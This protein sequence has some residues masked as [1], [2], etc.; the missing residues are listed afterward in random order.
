MKLGEY[1]K[2]RRIFLKLTQSELSTLL[3]I[4]PQC[5]S[6]YENEKTKIPLSIVLDLCYYL[7]ININDF[8][9]L[10]SHNNESLINLNEYNLDNVHK[11]IAFYR[12]KSKLTLKELSKKIGIS[13]QRLSDFELDKAS[14]SIDE[15]ILICNFYQTNYDDM[16]LLKEG[17]SSPQKIIQNT[18]KKPSKKYLY[19]GIAGFLVLASLSSLAISLGVM[20]S[21]PKEKTPLTTPTI[22]KFLVRNSLDDQSSTT[23]LIKNKDYYLFVYLDNAYNYPISSFEINKKVYEKE[24]FNEESTNKKVVVKFNSSILNLGTNDIVVNGF[25]YLNQDNKENF[26]A[27][28][29]TKYSLN[30]LSDQIPSVGIN[31]S[32]ISPTTIGGN[33]VIKNDTSDVLSS[34]EITLSLNENGNHIK[35]I[36]TKNDFTFNNLKPETEYQIIGTIKA[37]FY[38]GEGEKERT[39]FSIKLSTLPLASFE[40]LNSTYNSISYKLKIN[41]DKNITFTKLNLVD[42]ITNEII[43]E[44]KELESTINN[45]YSNHSYVFKYYV[46]NSFTDA[47]EELTKEIKTKD[48]SKP[49]IELEVINL[50]E[51]SF[52]IKPSVN[53][54]L[55]NLKMN[56]IEL[57]S[58]DSEKTIKFIDK[59]DIYSFT[60]LFSDSSYL[61]S[62][63]YSYDLLDGNGPINDTINLNVTTKSYVA[64]KVE[65]ERVSCDDTS[66]L[67]I[68]KEVKDKISPSYLKTELYKDEILQETTNLANY[69][70]NNLETN[71]NY[72]LKLYYSYN[73]NNGKGEVTEIVTTT[74]FTSS[75][76]FIEDLRPGQ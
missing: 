35:T 16:F 69:K 44:S 37:N 36:Q 75:D 34:K 41:D 13:I 57:T 24:I 5:L 46:F 18:P 27:L 54:S 55:D 45:L 71:Y 10:A 39:L 11:N 12:E 60:S 33:L 1:I 3:H 22:S 9:T 20:Y 7:K 32:T 15:Y 51:E 40:T 19:A 21:N 50:S 6:N 68:I 61:I 76:I 38:D 8:F 53:Y 47:Q 29:D 59:K 2:Q 28:K 58:F 26:V 17:A 74:A 66:I 25:S 73:L 49:H 48:V 23:T 30:V 70:F 65:F 52:D 31:A 64:P 72:V 14:P 42:S 4:T 63:N 56:Y 43:F 62:Y 67:I